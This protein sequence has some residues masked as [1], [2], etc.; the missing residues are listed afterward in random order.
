MNRETILRGW[1]G[2]FF[3]IRASSDARTGGGPVTSAIGHEESL[4]KRQLQASERLLMTEAAIHGPLLD[5]GRSAIAV[6][7][8]LAIAQVNSAASSVRFPES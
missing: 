3:H 1:V 5:D 2:G 4:V 7:Q 6:I 8:H